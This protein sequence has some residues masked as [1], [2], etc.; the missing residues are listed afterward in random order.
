MT[1]FEQLI[2]AAEVM[3]GAYEA[4][5][6]AIE[7]AKAKLARVEELKSLAADG[8]FD[9]AVLDVHEIGRPPPSP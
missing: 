7:E 5:V 1:T 3:K 9:A 4:L 8:Y 6:P 2:A